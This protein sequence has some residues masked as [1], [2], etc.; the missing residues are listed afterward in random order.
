MVT[1]ENYEEYM[2]LQADGEL[3]EAGTTALQAFLDGHPELADEMTL[4]ASLRLEPDT[5]MVY[6]GKEQLLQPVPAKRTIALGWRSMAAAAG[7]AALVCIA[8]WQYLRPGTNSGTDTVATNIIPA[9]PAKQSISKPAVSTTAGP[10][11]QAAPQP[12]V[13]TSQVAAVQKSSYKPQRNEDKRTQ[14]QQEA[15]ATLQPLH[16]PSLPVE[17]IAAGNIAATAPEAPLP[18]M[19]EEKK[20]K[21]LVALL[22]ISEEKKQGLEMVKEA[23]SQR[24]EQVKAINHNIKETALVLNI[25]QKGITI[26]F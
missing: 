26:N 1:L 25:G 22:P 19:K 3:D 6:T 12:A 2:M 21:D 14:H 16:T 10:Q 11:I 20:N 5:T 13:R 4:F 9:N 15:L 8:A 18:V 23:I 17:T 24:V 7:V